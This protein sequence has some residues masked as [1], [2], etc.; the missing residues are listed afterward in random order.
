MIKL[1]QRWL[2]LKGHVSDRRQEMAGFT[3]TFATIFKDFLDH[4]PGM[5]FHWLYKN[6]QTLNGLQKIGDSYEHG[7]SSNH[8]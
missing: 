3:Q 4:L 8:L 7:T 6:A 5:L 2:S 1:V